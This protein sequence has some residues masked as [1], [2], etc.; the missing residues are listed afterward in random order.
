[1]DAQKALRM[2]TNVPNF[3]KSVV[4]SSLPTATGSRLRA[5]FFFFSLAPLFYSFDQ[6]GGIF[7][8]GFSSTTLEKHYKFR[9]DYMTGR[10]FAAQRAEVPTFRNM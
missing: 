8:L 1:M 9:P 2:S 10:L 6:N 3:R 7:N 5:T 4:F